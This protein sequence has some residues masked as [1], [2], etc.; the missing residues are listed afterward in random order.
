MKRFLAIILVVLVLMV[1]ASYQN[2]NNLKLIISHLAFNNFIK[3]GELSYQ[4]ALF[5][6]VPAAEAVF[7]DKA[8]EDF[9]GGKVT[10]L[11]AEAK[12][13]SIVSRFFSARAGLDSYINPANGNPL[14]F[15]QEIKTGKSDALKKE[16]YY[17]QNKHIMTIGGEERTILPDTHDPLSLMHKLRRMDFEKNRNFEM[18]INTN[19]KNYVLTA[20]VTPREV[21]FDKKRYQL[22]LLKGDIKR[23]DKNPYHKS[24]ITIYFLKHEDV[25]LPILVKV[26]ASGV[27]INVKLIKVQ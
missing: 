19:Q 18:N 20:R 9:K 5:N 14:L 10:H 15:T 12:T 6:V 11:S 3:N 24:Y 2:N 21:S 4:V 7:K 22:F 8:G 27:L 17:D 23:R 16:I 13:S 1:M 26:F 25:N